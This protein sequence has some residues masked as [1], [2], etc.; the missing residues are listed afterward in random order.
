MRTK[1]SNEFASLFL[2]LFLPPSP[3]S[4]ISI[5]LINFWWRRENKRRQVAAGVRRQISVERRKRR[6]RSVGDGSIQGRRERRRVS[7]GVKSSKRRFSKFRCRSISN[8]G[9]VHGRTYPWDF[10]KPKGRWK[11]FLKTTCRIIIE[12]QRGYR[13]RNVIVQFN[14]KG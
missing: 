2:S 6:R 7:K 10:V 3:L 14:A 13:S 1:R 8:G 12:M 9:E 5:Y 4:L 11:S